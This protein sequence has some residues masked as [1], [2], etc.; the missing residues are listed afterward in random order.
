MAESVID[1]LKVVDITKKEEKSL[2]SSASA[3]ELLAGSGKKSA[4]I[5]KAGEIVREG[6]IPEFAVQ[7]SLLHR[8]P[9]GGMTGDPD[10][11]LVRVLRF[12]SGRN[13]VYLLQDLVEFVVRGLHGGGESLFQTLLTSGVL[14]V[15][16]E[17]SAIGGESGC[18]IRILCFVDSHET[19]SEYA[20]K[21][22][23][24]AEAII[25]RGID[26]NKQA[27][28]VIFCR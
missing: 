7:Q 28:P 27:E 8:A 16:I 11:A 1:F 14:A 2:G 3:L 6:E 23:F 5:I 15:H 21:G 19:S 4:A 20:A 12:Q 9:N 24:F 10:G 22:W 13:L 18:G 26:G 25:P 17:N